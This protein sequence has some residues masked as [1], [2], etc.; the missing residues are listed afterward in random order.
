MQYLPLPDNAARQYIDAV[1]VF[2]EHQRV[3][4]QA[5]KFAGSMYW[6]TESGYTYLVKTKPHSRLQERLGPRNAQTELAFEQ[7][8][9]QKARIEE[10]LRSLR[11]SLLEMQRMNKALR[12]G[13]VPN[14]VV[15]ILQRIH[16]AGLAQHFTVVGTHALYAYETAAGVRLAPSALAT[17][18]VDLLWDARRKVKFMADMTAQ[19]LSIIQV[20][21]RADPTFVR[22]ESH[23]ETAINARGFQV[24]FLR[25]Q[26]EADDPHPF[27]F[28]D[29]EDDLWPV[30]AMRASVLKSAPRFTQVV[31]S[32][33]GSM[34]YMHTISPQVFVEFKQWL[35]SQ[36][37]YREPIKQ[38]R[39]QLQADIVQH[40]LA[41][42]LLWS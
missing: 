41:S 8:T 15:N 36:A 28:S 24:D 20:L 32:S 42:G 2:E 13:R 14:L 38:R 39:D 33:N 3:W 11:E 7:Y 9:S 21:Q 4:A 31:V 27:R 10:R 23:N 18:D 17:Q 16:E 30:Q 19:G 40:L 37:Q 29:Q 25:R 12:V 1:S 22:K 26:T 34:A 5:Q 35:A 6:K